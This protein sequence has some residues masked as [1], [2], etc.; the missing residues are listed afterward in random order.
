MES[1]PPGVD[2]SL[3]PVTPPPYPGYKPDFDKKS[4]LTDV[5]IATCT[6]VVVLQLVFLSIRFFTKIKAKNSL[7]YDDCMLSKQCESCVT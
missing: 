5:T 3:I 7:A 2:L 4:E 6:I 1:L